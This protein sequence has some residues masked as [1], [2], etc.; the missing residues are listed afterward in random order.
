MILVSMERETPTLYHGTKQSYFGP[1]NFKFIRGVVT[2]P[3]LGKP[4][5]KKRLG[6]TRVKT[7]MKRFLVK[8][9]LFA[10]SLSE[11]EVIISCSFDFDLEKKKIAHPHLLQKSCGGQP[12]NYFLVSY[13]LLYNF[14]VASIMA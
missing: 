6:R 4:C 10:P 9:Y 2:T 1:V 13:C 14:K 11:K 7:C 12:N 8:A 5:F 3:P